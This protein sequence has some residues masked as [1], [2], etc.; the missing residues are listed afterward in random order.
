MSQPQ[1]ARR[2]GLF[3]AT[4]IV[5]GGIIGSG[6]FMNP[7]VVALQVRTPFLILGAWVVG[8]LFALAAAFIWAEL[9]SVRP[10][11]GGQ[12][13]YLREAFHPLVAFVYGWVLLL[14]IQTGG[15][16]AVAV[17]FSRYFVE[18]TQLPISYPLLA[19]IVLAVLTII[20]CLGVRA[21]STLQSVLMVLKIVALA[22]LVACG[23]LLAGRGPSPEALLDRAASFDLLTAFGAALVP[24]I[25]SYGGWQTATFVAGEIKEPRRN[26]PR[27]LILG[28]IGVVILYVAANVIY[29]SVLGT[30]GLAASAAPASDVMRNA[31][32][33]FGSRAIAAGIAISTV[34]FLSQS[35][36]TAPRVYFAMA[37]D[38]LFFKSVGMVHPT[39]RAPIVAIALQGVLAI[40]V[41]L[42]GTYESILNYVVSVDVIFFGL[43]ACCVFI[44]RNRGAGVGEGL[45]RV[46]GHPI[47]TMIFI[48]VC[49]LVAINTVYKY[50]RNTLIGI[51]IMAAGIPAY[52]FWRWR[53]RR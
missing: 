7:S 53:S 18:L 25:F 9:A 8:G 36:L 46:P 22:A 40:L 14:V 27:G 28:V 30:S 49:W 45:T 32:G 5:M 12:Y 24:V 23:L 52:W 44:F 15:M 34:G 1:L 2:L 6:I 26:L 31:L 43:T 37:N 38:G 48:A 19:A 16:A 13:A 33:N 41:A 17:T 3:D 21:G 50:P 11:V 35:M 39:T 29:I 20:N 4:M 42:L 10:D 47:T 51:G